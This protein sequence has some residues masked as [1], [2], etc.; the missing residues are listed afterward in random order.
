M[1][2]R[3]R[4]SRVE[5]LLDR[6]ADAVAAV[7]E[8]RPRPA[9][10][11]VVGVVPSGEA[12]WSM[13][14]ARS[15]R[16]AGTISRPTLVDSDEVVAWPP[17]ERRA[18]P[19]LGEAVAVQGRRVEVADADLPGPLECRGRH[20]H[21]RPARTARRWMLHRSPAGSRAGRSVRAA[22]VRWV[23]KARSI[24]QSTG[25]R[26]LT[27]C[28]TIAYRPVSR[29]SVSILNA[30]SPR[31]PHQLHLGHGRDAGRGRGRSLAG[32]LRL[33]PDG[34]R[35]MA[36]LLAGGGAALA[37]LR[38]AADP[39]RI[40][41]TGR[42]WT[43]SSSSRRYRARA[44]SWRSAATI[45][46][47][48]TEEGSSR[49]PRRSSSPS[50]RRSVVGDRAPRSA[51]TRASPAR[52]TGRPSSASSSG[53]G[54]ATCRGG[55]RA[56]LRPRLHVPERRV[57]PRHP[58][59]RR[60]VGPRQ[61]ARHVLP[62]GPGARHGRRDRRPAGPRDRLPRRRRAGPGRPHVADVLRRRRDRQLLLPLVHARARRR[63]RDGHAGRR[64]R[65]PRP[66]P[67][68]RRRRRR[69]RRDRAHRP[70]GQRLPDRAARASA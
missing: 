59:R 47:T 9:G 12:W 51:G 68:P 26:Q 22:P 52:S 42:P 29:P 18:D 24:A 2:M 46:S 28:T 7:V 60:A 35:T 48:S 4:P 43:A 38:A 70:A 16:S 55:G 64:R 23:R 54:R 39:A 6:P 20:R 62:D 44:R 32:G 37:A 13:S 61:V 49:R 1:S 50:G 14:A 33:L 66:A 45:E 56:R 36:E 10:R 65:L 69:H 58:V 21:R 67:L 11:V 31:A 27:S 34:P 63:D 19:P 17:P 5:A 53:G 3:S 30:G 40:A 25:R 15:D 57:R 8:H 41:E